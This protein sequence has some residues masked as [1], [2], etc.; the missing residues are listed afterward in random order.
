MAAVAANTA[1]EQSRG[2]DDSTA[3]MSG[4]SYDDDSAYL[5]EGEQDVADDGLYVNDE[6]PTH[7]SFAWWIPGEVSTTELRR[8]QFTKQDAIDYMK[9]LLGGDLNAWFILKMFLLPLITVV[10]EMTQICVRALP[11]YRPEWDIEIKEIWIYFLLKMS[12]SVMQFPAEEDYWLDHRQGAIVYPNFKIW[13]QRYRFLFI[14]KI[15]GF[16]NITSWLLP[17]QRTS[18]GRCMMQFLQ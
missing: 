11:S 3:D 5:D 1:A 15:Y 6:D 13:M 7:P 10:F 14:K 4:I 18:F 8:Y 17:R 16:Q 2:G 12:M 9:N